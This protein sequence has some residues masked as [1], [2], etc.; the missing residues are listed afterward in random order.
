MIGIDIGWLIA[1]L[2]FWGLL[3]SGSLAAVGLGED[4]KAYPKLRAGFV[5]GV[6]VF[7]PVA[8]PLCLLVA[9][10]QEARS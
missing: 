7:W 8:L 6:S 1:W 2:Y 3:A 5:L 4:L 10:W 9:L